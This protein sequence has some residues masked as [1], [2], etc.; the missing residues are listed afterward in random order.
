MNNCAVIC[1]YNPFHTGH[2]YQLDVMRAHGADNIF[3]I[4]SGSF[5]QSAMPAFCDKA[6]R[7]RCAVLGGCDAVIELPALYATS[8]AGYFARGG[9]KI[10]SQIQN[11]KTLAMGATASRDEILF[12]TEIKIKRKAELDGAVKK[13]LDSG[14]SYN[15]AASAALVDVAS[16]ENPNKFSESVITE[17]NNML[18]VEYICAIDEIAPNIQPLIIKREGASHG[19]SALDGDLSH[20]SATAIRNEFGDG[21]VKRYIPYLYDEIDDFRRDHAPDLVAYEKILLYSL[22]ASSRDKI[23][24]LRH[25]SDGMEYMFDT[26]FGTISEY[27]DAPPFRRFGKKR[28]RRLFL[29]AALG[30][31]KEYY[32]YDFCTRLLACKK[33][34]DFSL[35]PDTVFASNGELKARANAQASIVLGVDERA[36]DLYNTLC[37][38][39]GGYRNYSLVKV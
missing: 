36:A 7:A 39:D 32:D 9:V 10:A 13:L 26:Q 27:F 5:V 31:K 35:L 3:C 37:G 6:L 11:I 28:L 38:L 34:F 8:S 23:K 12:L 4:M 16:K 18:C 20:I 30:A 21:R 19:C 29:D 33:N 24:E 17:P 25:C 1:E 14:K 15:Y 22:K 2:E